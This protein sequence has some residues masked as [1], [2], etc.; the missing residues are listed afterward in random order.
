MNNPSY[1]LD[2]NGDINCKEIYINNCNLI[3]NLIQTSNFLFDYTTTSFSNVRNLSAFAYNSTLIDFYSYN[4]SNSFTVNSSNYI[5]THTCVYHKKLYDSELLI[6]ADFPYIIDGYGSDHYASRLS[7]SSE[8]SEETS[9]EYS[10]E[11][12]QVFIGYAAGGG[13]RSTTLS[14]ITHKTAISGNIITIKVQLK[15]I[16]SDDAITTNNCLFI[17]TEKKPTSKLVLERYITRED[18]EGIT[19][20]L[21]INPNQLS[22]ILNNYQ[23]NNYGKWT[24]NNSNAYINYDIGNVGIGVSTENSS[25]KLNLNGNLNCS[26]IYINNFRLLNTIDDNIKNSSNNLINYTNSSF[27]NTRNFNTFAYNSTVIDFY[28]FISSNSFTIDSSSYVSTHTCIYHKKLYDSELLIQ[29]DFPYI[30]NGFGSDHYSSRLSISSEN[31]AEGNEYSLEHQQ[32]FIGYAAGGGTRSTTLSP[33][34]H[35]TAISGNIITITV[36]IKLIDSDDSITTNNCL[37]VITE[38]K[39]TSKL[40]LTKY[41]DENE[42]VSITS[43]LYVSPFQLSTILDNYETNNYGK[44]NCNASS[45]YFTE[46]NVGIG[47]NI[48]R[49]KLHVYGNIVSTG[50]ISSAYSDIRLKKITS[51]ITN[52]LDTINNINGF[53][54]KHND[55]AKSFGYDDDEEHIG[56]SAQEV[57]NYIPEVVSLAPFDIDKNENGDIISKSGN[58]YLTVDYEKLVPYLIE[59]IKE[60]KKENENLNNRIKTIENIVL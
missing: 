27:D 42:V 38:K 1:N 19:S 44:W 30:I 48:P 17:I 47:T 35:T 55:L 36:Q 37:F 25:Y 22:L 53:K 3:T 41:I 5:T 60:L 14:P 23:T 4:S 20:N 26:D 18:V 59:C 15:L 31:I 28:S 52:A 56:V 40:V 13:T 9:E 29:A 50:Y 16:D 33:L 49:V 39:P 11:H 57:S 32:V 46:G 7:I 8:E 34:T 58:N 54:Y 43:N 21:Y 51:T 2:V 45:I 12:E 24:S 10:L 6:Q